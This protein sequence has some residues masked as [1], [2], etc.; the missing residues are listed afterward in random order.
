MKDTKKSYCKLSL[1][2]LSIGIERLDK[3]SLVEGPSRISQGQ[4]RSS[5]SGSAVQCSYLFTCLLSELEFACLLAHVSEL[6]PFAD[7][8]RHPPRCLLLI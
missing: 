5:I 4:W 7:I 3:S 1:R 6:L 2:L 8:L